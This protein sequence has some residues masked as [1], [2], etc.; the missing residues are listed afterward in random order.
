MLPVDTFA[1]EKA[2]H[3]LRNFIDTKLPVLRG[4]ESLKHASHVCIQ[5]CL[6]PGRW[7]ALLVV[8]GSKFCELLPAV[9]LI[10]FYLEQNSHHS[11]QVEDFKRPSLF[12]T[13]VNVRDSLCVL[14]CLDAS[15]NAHNHKALWY[16]P[17]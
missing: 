2:V 1:C 15:H 3:E 10:W 5:H 17:S 6:E 7:V 12:L 4:I 16:E 8:H 13:T 9:G 11:D 14:K